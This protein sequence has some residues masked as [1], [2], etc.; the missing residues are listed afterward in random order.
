MTLKTKIPPP[1][2]MLTFAGIMWLLDRYAP[3][4]HWNTP[5]WTDIG[6]GIMVTGFLIDLSSI[7]LFLRRKTSPNPMKPKK[8]SK[9]VKT[10]L[11]RYTRNPMYLG[12]LILLSG[13]SIQ[14]GSLSPLVFP[15]LL[16]ITLTYLQIIP[17]EIA[18]SEV[19]GKPYVAYK[20]SVPRWL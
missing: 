17:E 2:Y 4:A 12:M 16:L 3:I 6:W 10:G 8:A 18:L 11:Y 14:L 19:L 20:N 1:V 13:W 5:P 9:L 15:P 7:T